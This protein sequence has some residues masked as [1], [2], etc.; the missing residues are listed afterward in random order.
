M[1]A[2]PDEAIS[3]S[4]GIGFWY[5]AYLQISAVISVFALAAFLGHFV[6]LNW[7]GVLR[8]MVGVWNETVRPA[9]NFL[10][11]ITIVSL[12][13]WALNW[14]I[15][16]PLMVRDYVAV[17][18]AL[19]LSIIRVMYKDILE[20]SEEKKPE[21]ETS[22]EKLSAFEELFGKLIVFP[23]YTVFVLV[24]TLS[25]IIIALLLCVVLW[26]AIIAYS[27]KLIML[28][29]YKFVFHKSYRTSKSRSRAGKYVLLTTITAIL[30]A[31]YL[32]IGLII[33]YTFL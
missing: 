1:S 9:V 32:I 13:R 27:V 20:N 14:H 11:T 26:P 15:T 18:I 16:I 28:I 4:K 2:E 24:K 22:E 25:V 29:S 21:E 30:P 10:L 17:G 19:Y 33:N 6:P 5:F 23:L 12:L 3:Q 31:I 8:D 7:H